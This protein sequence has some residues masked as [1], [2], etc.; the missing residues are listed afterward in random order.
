M[1]IRKR[2]YFETGNI[3][4]GK[5]GENDPAALIR[6]FITEGDVLFGR[7]VDEGTNPNQI[8]AVDSAAIKGIAGHSIDAS[9]LDNDT[10]KTDDTFALAVRGIYSVKVEVDIVIG[11]AV[12]YRIGG[13]G[14]AGDFLIAASAGNTVEITAGAEWRSVSSGTG[15]NRR[16]LL[17]INDD[18]FVTSADV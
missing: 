1:A 14:T 3:L 2:D 9:D 7:A 15:T 17:Y 5:P 16:A 11:D 13:A 12:R 10:Y 8:K 4:L 6:S 18:A